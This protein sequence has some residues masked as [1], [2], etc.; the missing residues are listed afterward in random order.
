MNHR[1]GLAALLSACALGAVSTAWAAPPALD[2]KA[3]EA[4]FDAQIDP[5]EMGGW[6]KLLAAEPNH[7]GSAHDKANAEWIAA[8]L[9]SWGW[10]AKIETFD[11]LYP[12]PISEG[13]ELVG[14]PGAPFKATLTE[15]PVPGDQAT[16]TKDALPAYVAFQGDGDVTAPLVYVNYGMPEDYLAL[17]RMGISVKGKI[18]IARYGGGW[19]GL[20][21]LLAQMHGAAGSI[22]YSD[23]KDDGYGA[24]DVYPKGPARPK[25]GFQRGSVADM[26]IYPGDPLTPGV[27]STKDAKRLDR[28]DAQTILKI[29]CL[30]I[31]YGDAQVL[32]ASLDGPVAPANWRGG[33]PITYHVGGSAAGGQVHLAVKSDWSQKTL[34]DV[35]GTLKGAEAPNEWIVR[36]N[37]HDGWVMGASDP[38]SGQIALLAEAKA[39][40]ALMKSGWKPKK[41]IVYTSWDGEEPMLLGSTEWAETHADELKAKALVYINSDGN[42]RG[43]LNAAGSHAF[44]HFI[45]QVAADVKDPETGV[46]VADRLRARLAVNAAE[47]GANELAKAAGKAAGDP[48]KDLPVGPLGSGSDYSAFLQHLGLA[49]IDFAY[50]GEGESGGVYHSLYDDYEHHSRFVDPGFAYDATLAKTVGRAVMRLADADLPVQRYGDFADTVSGYVDEVKKLADGKRDEARAQAKLLSGR[51]YALA[52]DPTHPHADPAP[53]AQSPALDFAALDSALTKLKA[54][55]KAFDTALSAKGEALG[56]AQKVKLDAVI[57]PLEQSLLRPE[58]LPGRPWYM[59]MVYAPG[60]F[61]GYGAKTLPGVREA[62]EERRFED[63]QKYVGVTAQALEAYAANL[64]KATAIVNG[65]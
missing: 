52:A 61:T 35:V 27:G 7:V 29:P 38:L 63:A 11:V 18:A 4:K 9:K 28:K 65:G 58:G 21:P 12:T 40:G 51:A 44:Q 6:L 32:L 47:P 16:Y 8:Q 64:D 5:A 34:Y 55:S 17:E 10:D 57:R 25:G 48:T 41:T 23:P 31:S 1:I 19:R 3:L 53:L 62:I 26:P 15:P 37:H 42:G 22:I 2:A 60:R 49:S 24:D 33:L 56:A 14:G 20:K 50:G 39:F 54:S 45:N 59:N 43:F 30:P 36:G 46:S 13:L